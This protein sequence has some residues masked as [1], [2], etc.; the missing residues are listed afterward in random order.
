LACTAD[1]A[2]A[3]NIASN[4]LNLIKDLSALEQAIVQVSRDGLQPHL[5]ASQVPVTIFQL[6]GL[7]NVEPSVVIKPTTS[8]TDFEECW[9]D[10]AFLQRL[11]IPNGGIMRIVFP[12]VAN[13]DAGICYVVLF[14][15]EDPGYHVGTER[16]SASQQITQP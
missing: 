14:D 3:E 1:I 9:R 10:V 13:P 8:E 2:F 12:S 16:C 11:S 4:E 15:Q 7:E 5:A 6:E